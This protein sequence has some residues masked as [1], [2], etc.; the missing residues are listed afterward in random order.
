MRPIDDAIIHCSATPND[1]DIGAAEIKIWHTE[2]NGWRDIGYHFVIR[3]DGTLELGRP[4]E[5]VGAHVAGKNTRSIGICLIGDDQFTEAQFRTLTNLLL[6]LKIFFPSMK[7]SGHNDWTN[8]KTCPNFN[9]KE[10][11]REVKIS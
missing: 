2:G 1:R 3:R 9:V 5:Q 4:L 11:Y 7:V 8:A 10:W 6:V